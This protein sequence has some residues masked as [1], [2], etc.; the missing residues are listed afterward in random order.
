LTANIQAPIPETPSMVGAI[1][2]FI[3]EINKEK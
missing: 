1:D 2:K 3:V